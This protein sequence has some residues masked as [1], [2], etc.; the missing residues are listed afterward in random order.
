MSFEKIRERYLKGYINDSQLIRFK[1]LGIISED[2]Y[3]ILYTPKQLKI[4]LR[5]TNFW[6]SETR[7]T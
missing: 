3:N 7:V 2:E 6:S 4:Q 1:D 5:N